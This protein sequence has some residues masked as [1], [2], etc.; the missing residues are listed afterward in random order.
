MSRTGLVCKS[1]QILCAFISQDKANSSMWP[2]RLCG[3]AHLPF[4]HLPPY[5][6][7]PSYLGLLFTMLPPTRGLCM[8]SL[9]RMFS[10]LP[11][12]WF[13]LMLG[14]RNSFNPSWPWWVKPLLCSQSTRHL[15]L[16]AL[17]TVAILYLLC[18]YMINIYFSLSSN[19][20]LHE[21]RLPVLGACW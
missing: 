10:L 18:D 12:T 5:S 13:T 11:F 21:G 6:L 3:M 20:K 16:V 17:V 9:P 14:D 8:F 19:Y 4:Q 15:F 7:Y 1:D 2:T